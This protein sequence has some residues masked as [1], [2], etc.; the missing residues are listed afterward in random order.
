MSELATPT[1]FEPVTN[2]LEGYCSIQLS[3]GAAWAPS[4]AYCR[5]CQDAEAFDGNKN[6]GPG[7]WFAGQII[8]LLDFMLC[9]SDM[10]P[11]AGWLPREQPAPRSKIVSLRAFGGMSA[12]GARLFRIAFPNHAGFRRF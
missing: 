8:C 9:Q 3:Y 2:S 6:M 10:S 12:S 4:S 7:A 11:I 1:G 5:L